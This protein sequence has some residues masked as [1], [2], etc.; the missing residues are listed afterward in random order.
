[1][2]ARRFFIQLV[3][4]FQESRTRDALL[5]PI[6]ESLIKSSKRSFLSRTLDR[7]CPVA[8]RLL[9]PLLRAIIAGPKST[10]HV[11]GD[12]AACVRF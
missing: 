6:D 12:A 1:M 10:D 4:G 8:S 11:C 9:P 7:F 3:L 5:Q 2:S